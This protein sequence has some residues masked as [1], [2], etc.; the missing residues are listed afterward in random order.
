MLLISAL[1]FLSGLQLATR[2]GYEYRSECLKMFEKVFLFSN[3]LLLLVTTPRTNRR[4]LARLL[5]PLALLSWS[6]PVWLVCSLAAPL[7]S[8]RLCFPTARI[9]TMCAWGGAATSENGNRRLRHIV[10]HGRVSPKRGG[11]MDRAEV[12]IDREPAQNKQR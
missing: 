2:N 12:A 5:C 6:L 8:L 11:H 1:C 3:A 10:A 7:F 9:K 4:L